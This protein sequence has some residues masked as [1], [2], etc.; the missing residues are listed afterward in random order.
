MEV[1]WQPSR[2]ERQSFHS[3]GCLRN[4]SG[5]PDLKQK[6]VS[7]TSLWHESFR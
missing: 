5:N 1:V 4:D 6:R 3:E 2:T 7:G